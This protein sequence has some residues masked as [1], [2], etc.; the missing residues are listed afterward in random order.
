MQAESITNNCL[1]ISTTKFCFKAGKGYSKTAIMCNSTISNLNWQPKTMSIT[2]ST[3]IIS[4]S[5]ISALH[6]YKTRHNSSVV[7]AEI[8]MDRWITTTP[9]LLSNHLQPRIHQVPP[10]TT[11]RMFLQ[12]SP[13]P[14]ILPTLQPTTS[15]CKSSSRTNSISLIFS[16]I[17]IHSKIS[18]S[19]SIL[20]THRDGI[21]FNR[22]NNSSNSQLWRRDHMVI[23][24]R[25]DTDPTRAGMD[26]RRSASTPR[27]WPWAFSIMSSRN[28]AL[29]RSSRPSSTNNSPSHRWCRGSPSR[30]T[31]RTWSRR[32][33]G[34][35][36]LSKTSNTSKS[37]NWWTT[38]VLSRITQPIIGS[39]RQEYN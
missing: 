11:P 8:T 1:K 12:T 32:S 3:R 18:N 35:S 31:T 30:T 38:T 16:R 29:S 19:K 22:C 17:R 2:T 25:V 34:S 39:S 14:N 9:Q 27:T 4:W 20:R 24:A 33:G 37:S 13:R 6:R 10:W 21:S 28:Q 23:V 26:R 15:R 36:R 7:A 5:L